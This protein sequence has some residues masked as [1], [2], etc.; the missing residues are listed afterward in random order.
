ML[1]VAVGLHLALEGLVPDPHVRLPGPV[2]GGV[3]PLLCRVGVL[4]HLV[5]L[6]NPGQAQAMGQNRLNVGLAGQAIG[7]AHHRRGALGREREQAHLLAA[8]RQ[9]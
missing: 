2:A 3:D 8:N 6:G 1:V 4:P 5:A 9:R 7:E